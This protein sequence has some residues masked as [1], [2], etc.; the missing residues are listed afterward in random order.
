MENLGMPN[1]SPTWFQDFTQQS[2]PQQG[3]AGY[4]ADQYTDIANQY[5]GQLAG[6][7]QQYGQDALYNPAFLRAQSFDGYQNYNPFDDQGA[8][9]SIGVPGQN[10][11]WNYNAFQGL[12]GLDGATDYLSHYINNQND[13]R[14]NAKSGA[15]P[16][17][18]QFMRNFTNYGDPFQVA[19]STRQGI[20]G[21]QQQYGGY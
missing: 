12:S 13:V 21:L 4:Y 17:D 1:G 11:D 14:K 8:S 20:Y 19:D 9:G 6:L 10:W 7:G 3:Q 16:G 5:G 18:Q 2:G 15:S